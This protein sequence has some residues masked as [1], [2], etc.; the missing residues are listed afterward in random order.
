M[1]CTAYGVPP[2]KV[3]WLRLN[4]EAAPL[5]SEENSPIIDLASNYARKNSC[6]VSVPDTAN[7]LQIY[8]SNKDKVERICFVQFNVLSA[9]LFLECRSALAPWHKK[10]A[11]SHFRSLFSKGVH[12]FIALF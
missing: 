12:S 7:I 3:T 10:R 9:P 8:R 2:P 11:R 1:D 4:P 5:L 6:G